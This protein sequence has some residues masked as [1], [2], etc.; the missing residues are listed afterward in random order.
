[1]TI[2]LEV[3]DESQSAAREG[4]RV[5]LDLRRRLDPL[6]RLDV[7]QVFVGDFRR[8][9][10]ERRRRPVFSSRENQPVNVKEWKTLSSS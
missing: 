7:V 2:Y 9:A 1:M 10:R 6:T 4:H 8:D 3:V 5:D